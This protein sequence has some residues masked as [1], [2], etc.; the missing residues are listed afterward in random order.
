M[1]GMIKLALMATLLVCIAINSQAAEVE[2]EVWINAMS[3]ALPTAFCQ[4]GQFFRQCFEV[5]QIEC[6][7]TAAS[8]TRICL[9]KYKSEIPKV[10]NQPQDGSKWGRIIGKCAGEA[11]GIALQ[12]KFKNNPKCND[13]SHWQ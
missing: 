11:Y 5:T 1:K 2:K 6:E 10:L 9:G 7:E 8:A 13:P 4:S 3:T 12:Q